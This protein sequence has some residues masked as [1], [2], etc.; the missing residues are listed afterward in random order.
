[1]IPIKLHLSGF[2]SYQDPVVLDF[3]GLD[4]ACISGS[5]GAGKSSLL[6]AITWVLFGQARCR[7]D[8]ALINGGASVKAAEII[9]D[10]AYEGN[11]YRVQRSKPR[12]K[13]A[14]LEFYVQTEEGSWRPLTEKSVRETENRMRQILRLDYDTFI[15]ASFF[16]QGRADMFAQQNPTNRKKVLSSV[17]GLEVWETYRVQAGE[18]R[19]VLE[20]DLKALDAQLAEIETELGQE[21][22]RKARLEA[23]EL[24]LSQ[25]TEL[26]KAREN[27]LETLRR[28]AASLNDQKRLVDVL[29]GQVRET[30]AR[31]ERLR[32]QV[33]QLETERENL[34]ARVSAAAETQAG[35]QAWLE[36]RAALERWDAI[37]ASFHEI[38]AK[39]SGPLAE[40]AA[41]RSRLDEERRGLLQKAGTAQQE[42]TRLAEIQTEIP[43]VQAAING[44]Q[45]RLNQRAEIEENI[46]QAQQQSA[47]LEAENRRL[48]GEM[49]ALKERIE[50]L[51]LTEGALCPLCGQ[52]L[53][54]ADREN[55]ILGLEADGKTMGDTFRANQKTVEQAGQAM[56]ELQAG[57]SGLVKHEEELRK[58]TRRLDQLESDVA[59]LDGT[60]QAWQSG[61]ALRLKEV[62]QHISTEDYA[63]EARTRLAE[64][65]A[66]ARE[67]G[68]DTVAHDQAR[69]AE[70]AGRVWEQALRELESA[71]ASLEPLERQL[72]GLN[73]QLAAEVEKAQSQET[74]YC[75]AA[76]KY[77]ADQAAMPDLDQAE[78]EALS[79]QSEENR[80]RMETG[81]VRQLVAVLDTQRERKARLSAQ[82]SEV[83]RQISRL[84]VLERAFGKDGV[85]AL[86]IEQ[87]LPEIETQAND[88][89]DRLTAGSMSVRFAT[90]RQ[91]KSKD[92]KRETLDILISDASGQREYEMFSGGEAFRV[93][94]A[95]RLA[96]SRVLAHRAGARLQTLF[97]DEGFGSQ[98]ADGRQRLLEAI[99]LVRPEFARILVIT[100]L[101]EMKEAFP[102][103]IEVEKTPRGSNLRIV[104]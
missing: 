50:R 10:F 56:R 31:R 65:D 41:E 84:K 17:L 92:E 26:R 37:A 75:A 90:Q 96:L 91:L 30:Q 101:E 103:R 73:E 46:R 58:Q 82:R 43:Q 12:G 94:F 32:N 3:D 9:F 28:L 25:L 38:Q 47:D 36:Q 42:Q 19:K 8:E 76:E 39:R 33:G 69:K 102:A 4:L 66:S 88:L 87:A 6:D 1:M 67:L 55:L 16:L 18:Q 63:Q 59:R 70:Q 20:S 72:A 40:I 24:R 100:H 52:P 68:Y 81:M 34:S 95:I 71:R 104:A 49:S 54:P 98:D 60:I 89:L 79:M 44:V 13:S 93:N 85:P 62:E 64:I 48:R 5:N 61:G 23:I 86:L 99:N 7:D 35:Y 22:E 83:T 97:I 29:A 11:H 45:E 78:K 74:E 2:L 27:A 14:L 80:L 57:L 21:A 51:K 15:N 53:S 77:Q